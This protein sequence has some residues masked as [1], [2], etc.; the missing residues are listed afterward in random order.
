MLA[1]DIAGAMCNQISMSSDRIYQQ[2]GVA[3]RVRRKKQSLTQHQLAA[4]VGVSRAALANIETGRQ[5]VF[6][7]QLYAL[8]AALQMT[9]H[10]LLPLAA[11]MIPLSAS[12]HLPLPEGLNPE[13]RNQIA[14]LVTGTDFDATRKTEK[15]PRRRETS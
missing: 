8:A 4:Q 1:I 6:V 7:H 10:E 3:I 14:H 2:I 5:R 12:A 11:K 15:R 9:P 13:Q